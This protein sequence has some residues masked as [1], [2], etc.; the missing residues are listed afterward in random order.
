M[1]IGNKCCLD[2]DLIFG[3][4]RMLRKKKCSK[5]TITGLLIVHL[6]LVFGLPLIIA[7]AWGVKVALAP[8]VDWA[9]GLSVSLVVIYL[10]STYIA[11]SNW[12]GKN[13]EL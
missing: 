3:F 12:K 13:W 5:G 4:I 1:I 2:N 11:F 7:F 10:V 9:T 8:D 6:F